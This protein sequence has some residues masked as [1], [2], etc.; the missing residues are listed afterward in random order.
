ME[1]PFFLMR[2]SAR[3]MIASCLL[4][5]VHPLLTLT[6]T[7]DYVDV[8]DDDA[9]IPAVT[10]E[11]ATH[12][13]EAPHGAL[14][15][16]IGFDS[17]AGLT[18]SIEMKPAGFGAVECGE[19]L[20]ACWQ[21][22]GVPEE[23]PERATGFHLEQP[24]DDAPETP[25]SILK[26]PKESPPDDSAESVCPWVRQQHC[27]ARQEAAAADFDLSHDVLH[28]LKSVE[29]G[30][31]AVGERPGIRRRR[32]R[33]RGAGLSR[34]GPRPLPRQPHRRSRAGSRRVPLRSR[35]LRIAFI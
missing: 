24:A 1:A 16:S 9:L 6:P 32:P 19:M 8:D 14:I 26:T 25:E 12:T 10:F 17:D 3:R 15:I 33:R 5:G 2:P 22:I 21:L 23:Q 35:L 4:F 31:D 18:G 13:E 29:P 20:K 7:E 11:P 28:N 27:A 30:S 34:T